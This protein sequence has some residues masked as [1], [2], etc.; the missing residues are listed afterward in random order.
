MEDELGRRAALGW[1]L[2]FGT[3]YSWRPHQADAS[4]EG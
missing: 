3:L 4:P 2:G 1:E